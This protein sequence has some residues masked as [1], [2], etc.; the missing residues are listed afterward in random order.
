MDRGDDTPDSG[1]TLAAGS[2]PSPLLTHVETKQWAPM[3]GG[4]WGL[5]PADHS[6]DTPG[7]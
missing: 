4:G 1:L 3:E 6:E 7:Y 5:N 2:G